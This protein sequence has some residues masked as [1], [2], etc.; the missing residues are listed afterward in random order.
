MGFKESTSC[1]DLP[2]NSLWGEIRCD[3]PGLIDNSMIIDSSSKDD[4][5]RDE[6][7]PSFYLLKPGLAENTDFVLVP[8]EAFDLLN[9]KYNSKQ[10][11]IRYTINTQ[12]SVKVE[13]YLKKINLAF[14]YK[15]NFLVKTHYISRNCKIQDII[16]LLLKE[17]NIKV[18]KTFEEVKI[19]KIDTDAVPVQLIVAAIKSKKHGIYLKNSKVLE[20]NLIIEESEI[21]EQNILFLDHKFYQGFFISPDKSDSLYSKSC[22]S[23]KKPCESTLLCKICSKPFCSKPCLTSHSTLH[24]KKLFSRKS[25]FNIFSCFCQSADKSDSEEEK[26]IYLAKSPN[27]S[28]SHHST[29][30]T[31]PTSSLNSSLKGLQNLGNTCFMN[32]AIQCLVHSEDIRR[33]FIS[34]DYIKKINKQNPLGTKGKLAIAYGELLSSMCSASEKSVAPWGLKK[35]ITVV[36]SQ[37]QGYQQHDSHEFLSY[38]IN[39]LHEDLNEITKKPYY[40]TDIKFSN[41][42]EVAEESWR[43]HV[44]RNKSFIAEMM[45]GQYKSTLNCPKCLKYSYA[46]DPFNCLSLPIPHLQK[47][48]IEVS[49]V[50]YDL[51]NDGLLISCVID[52]QSLVMDLKKQVSEAISSDFS[53]FVVFEVRPALCQAS[54]TSSVSLQRPGN[55]YMYQVPRRSDKYLFLCIVLDNYAREPCPRILEF[56]SGAEVPDILD[57]IYEKFKELFAGTEV[58]LSKNN[59]E[60][61]YKVMTYSTRAIECFNCGESNCR[62]CEILPNN[63]KLCRYLAKADPPMLKISFTQGIKRKADLTRL[64]GFKKVKSTGN[65]GKGKQISLEDCFRTFSVP[66][67]LDTHNLWYCPHCKDHVQASKQLEIYRV[68]KILIIHLKRFRTIGFHREKLNAPIRFP[69][70]NLDIREFVIGENPELY[71]LYAVSNHF[72]LLSGGHY[73]ATVQNGGKWYDCDDSHI[74]ETKDVSETS[75]YVL[76][77][78]ARNLDNT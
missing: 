24:K 49:Y 58:N 45:Y 1:R 18:P 7:S 41:D 57:S 54:D 29:T 26:I 74:T 71:E 36:A 52:S 30:S 39:G 46:F 47:K 17:I 40:E 75:A 63:T 38:L 20:E 60:E 42:K 67:V 77:Y 61:V 25:V 34:G 53:E 21:S 10:R 56:D 62:K 70:D 76:F 72:G 59:V 19:W 27:P 15:E 32:S 43:R 64:N 14:V 65:S 66:E 12:D 51:H 4:F 23:C 69:K 68:P 73:T 13:V 55:Y 28:Y 37:F 3:N 48:N 9:R 11:V 6:R 8:E 50:P 22:T 31:S 16:V 78:R 33:F 35:T 44:S 5:A 2:F